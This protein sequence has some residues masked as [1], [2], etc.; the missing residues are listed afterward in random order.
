[1]QHL[2]FYSP[3]TTTTTTTATM[4]AYP[5][6][7]TCDNCVQPQPV[8]SSP[9]VPRFQY[10]A[11]LRNEIWQRRAGCAEWGRRVGRGGGW[12]GRA[13]S[14]TCKRQRRHNPKPLDC[15]LNE[16][17]S[18]CAYREPDQRHSQRQLQKRPPND[19]KQKRPKGGPS[20][21]ERSGRGGRGAGWD[22]GCE[23]K[24]TAEC[25]SECEIKIHNYVYAGN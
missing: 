19:A 8:H 15:R 23:K 9:R 18:L 11:F 4:A 25:E 16:P 21:L 7:V 10:R 20:Q 17:R 2:L 12:Q 1:M 3:A 13:A 6:H 22:R 5:L 24:I 14:D